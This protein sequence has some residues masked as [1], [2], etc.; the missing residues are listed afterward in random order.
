VSGLECVQDGKPDPRDF[1]RWERGGSPQQVGERPAADQLH[2]D[3]WPSVL[4]DDVED[5]DR[6]VAVDGSDGACLPQGATGEALAV[7][8]RE[9]RREVDLLH[10]YGAVQQLVVRLPDPAHP[11]A[12]ELR[13]Q[14]VAL[15][16]QGISR[17]ENAPTPRWSGSPTADGL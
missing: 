3:P 12:A 11:A 13:L 16:D 9:V 5:P 1:S 14:A 17:H 7:R 6:G 10:S 2:H 8:D 4:L 15:R